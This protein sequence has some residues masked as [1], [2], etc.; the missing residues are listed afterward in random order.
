MKDYFLV[1]Q[2]TISDEGRN[3]SFFF[4]VQPFTYQIPAGIVPE[5]KAAGA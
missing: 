3:F 5:D 1:I 2:S 4:N